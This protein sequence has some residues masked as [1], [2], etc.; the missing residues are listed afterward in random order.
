VSDAGAIKENPF[1]FARHAVIELH[2]YD[3]RAERDDWR[4]DLLATLG[5]AEGSPGERDVDRLVPDAAQWA[6]MAA[7]GQ[8][9]SVAVASAYVPHLWQQTAREH[10]E[11]PDGAVGV[12][13]T[14]T[15]SVSWDG[16]SSR[17]PVAATVLLL[18]P[19]A[20]ERCVVSRITTRVAR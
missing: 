4:R 17:V 18:C 10:P 20:V 6:Q 7:I 15:Q 2:R 11:L 13:V 5:T 3:T 16:G 19:P 9:T 14:G 1:A 8:R 12:T